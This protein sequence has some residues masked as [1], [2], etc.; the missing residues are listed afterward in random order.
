M[1]IAHMLMFPTGIITG[2]GIADTG[3][4]EIVPRARKPPGFYAGGWGDITNL[5]AQ[6]PSAPSWG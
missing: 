5:K 1:G 4:T 6:L 3:T 2:I